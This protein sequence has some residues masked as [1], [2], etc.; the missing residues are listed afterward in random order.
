MKVTVQ[1]INVGIELNDSRVV[2]A[3]EGWP[4]LTVRK[5]KTLGELNRNLIDILRKIFEVTKDDS[6]YSSS[7]NVE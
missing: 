5:M 2:K 4:K 1:V 3:L 7:S 6:Y